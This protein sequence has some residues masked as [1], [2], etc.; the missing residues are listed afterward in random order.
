[1]NYCSYNIIIL[2]FS[3]TSVLVLKPQILIINEPATGQDFLM[4]RQLMNL[5]EE[6]NKE[7]KTIITITH[8]PYIITKYSKE[9]VI[10]DDGKLIQKMPTSEFL[11]NK[12]F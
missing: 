3:N 5:L 4:I 8:N 7:N 9:V 10:L 1:M 6:L 12:K 2:S 11:K